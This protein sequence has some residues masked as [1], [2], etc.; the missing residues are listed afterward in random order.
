MGVFGVISAYGIY[1]FIKRQF[2]DYMFMKTA[3]VFFDFG[4]PRIFFFL[5]YITVMVLFAMVGH[6][7]VKGLSRLTTGKKKKE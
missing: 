7:A 6:F 5:D 4:E 3:F 2:P 1:A